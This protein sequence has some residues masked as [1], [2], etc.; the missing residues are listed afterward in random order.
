M[1][2]KYF[3]KGVDIDYLFES[4]SDGSLGSFSDFPRINPSSPEGDYQNQDTMYQGAFLQIGSELLNNY[5]LKKITILTSSTGTDVLTASDSRR[6]VN[7]DTS[8]PMWTHFKFSISVPSG[9]GTVGSSHGAVTWDYLNQGGY[10]GVNNAVKDYI[11]D[12]NSLVNYNAN[13]HAA[14]IADQTTDG[15]TN[16]HRA[17]AGGFFRGRRKEARGN[18]NEIKNAIHHRYNIKN[19]SPAINQ[20]GTTLSLPATSPGSNG[21]GR[22]IQSNLSKAINI[23]GDKTIYLRKCS[24]PRGDGV[25]KSQQSQSYIYVSKE[26]VEQAD[27]SKLTFPY[28]FISM[29][30]GQSCSSSSGGSITADNVDHVETESDLYTERVGDDKVVTWHQIHRVHNMG[31]DVHAGNDGTTGENSSIVVSKDTIHSGNILDGMGTT[32]IPPGG[33]SAESAFNNASVVNSVGHYEA[34]DGN[35]YTATTHNNNTN[36]IE[37]FMIYNP[38]VDTLGYTELNY[39]PQPEPE[40]EPEPEPE[41]DSKKVHKM[42]F[43]VQSGTPNINQVAFYAYV[44]DQIQNV[45]HSITDSTTSSGQGGSLVIKDRVDTDS[46]D[47]ATGDTIEIALSTDTTSDIYSS[48][49]VIE[50]DFPSEIFGIGFY[51]ETD[52]SGSTIDT[53]IRLELF[54]F[55][56]VKLIDI[57]DA[58]FS[59]TVDD[60][61]RSFA[62]R[63]LLNGTYEGINS[64]IDS[65]PAIFDFKEDFDSRTVE[66]YNPSD[67]DNDLMEPEPEP[68]PQPEPEFG[69]WNEISPD[70]DSEIVIRYIGLELPGSSINLS[71]ILVEASIGIDDAEDHDNAGVFNVLSEDAAIGTYVKGLPENVTYY[72]TDEGGEVE[73]LTDSSNNVISSG[74][75]SLLIDLNT[76]SHSQSG[77]TL[78]QLVNCVIKL[79]DTQVISGTDFDGLTARLYDVDMDL[80][81]E[82]TYTVSKA[83]EINFIDPTFSLVDDFSGYIVLAFPGFITAMVGTETG[84]LK[85]SSSGDY[86]SDLGTGTPIDGNIWVPFYIQDDRIDYEPAPEPEPEAPSDA[87]V[88]PSITVELW[89]AAGSA[90]AAIYGGHSITA[91]AGGYVRANLK[92]ASGTTLYIYCGTQPV[93]KTTSST[94]ND[95]YISL[96]GGWNGGGNGIISGSGSSYSTS[97]ATGYVS[98][99][100]GSTD[101]RL[102]PGS[103]L[104]DWSDT[105]S[106]NSRIA[107]AGGAGGAGGVGADGGHLQTNGWGY[108]PGSGGYPTGGSGYSNS[109]DVRAASGGTQSAGG[110]GGQADSY[111]GSGSNGG[112]GYGGSGAAAYNFGGQY[113]GGSGGGGGWYGGGGAG[114][115]RSGG[116]GSSYVDSEYL[117]GEATYVSQRSFPGPNSSY[118]PDTGTDGNYNSV[119][120][121]FN[122]SY[123]TSSPDTGGDGA[124]RITDWNGNVT[125]FHPS[126]KGWITG[127]YWNYA[128]YQTYVVPE[129]NSLAKVIFSAATVNSATQS[130]T[131]NVILHSGEYNDTKTVVGEVVV[132]TQY[133]IYN[134]TGDYWKTFEIEIYRENQVSL[135]GSSELSV[136]FEIVPPSGNTSMAYYDLDDYVAIKNIS[137]KRL[138]DSN[139]KEKFNNVNFS[140]PDY[141]TFFRTYG[142]YDG[143]NDS[144]T[145]GGPITQFQRFPYTVHNYI[146][147]TKLHTNLPLNR[148]ITPDSCE[149]S[150]TLAPATMNIKENIQKQGDNDGQDGENA[151]NLLKNYDKFPGKSYAL[152]LSDES[153]YQISIE[154]P[155]QVQSNK[156]FKIIVMA[157]FTEDWSGTPGPDTCTLIHSRFFSSYVKNKLDETSYEGDFAFDRSQT[158]YSSSSHSQDGIVQ[159]NR[160]RWVQYMDII[161]TDDMTISATGVKGIELYLGYNSVTTAGKIYIGEVKIL[162]PDNVNL[163]ENSRFDRGTH[164]RDIYGGVFDSRQGYGSYVI[165]EVP[166]LTISDQTSVMTSGNSSSADGT[167]T[168]DRTNWKNDGPMTATHALCLQYDQVYQIR[169]RWFIDGNAAGHSQG[170]A[171]GDTYAP[172]SDTTAGPTEDVGLFTDPTLW[173]ESTQWLEEYYNNG[174]VW[175]IDVYFSEDWDG[176]AVGFFDGQ[177]N[178]HF[179]R[180]ILSS[181]FKNNVNKSLS[182]RTGSREIGLIK[183]KWHRIYLFM[184]GNSTTGYGTPQSN[185][186]QGAYHTLFFNRTKGGSTGATKG[187]VLITN[188]TAD[189]AYGSSGSTWGGRFDSLSHDF[190]SGHDPARIT[191]SSYSTNFGYDSD[192]VADTE[193][194]TIVSLIERDFRRDFIISN[195]TALKITNTS[196]SSSYNHGGV[197]QINLGQGYS[198]ENTGGSVVNINPLGDA[199]ET[200]TINMK[201]YL[202]DD[203]FP[204]HSYGTVH[205]MIQAASAH[206]GSHIVNCYGDPVVPGWTLNSDISSYRN[207]WIDYTF[208]TP[209][210]ASSAGMLYFTLGGIGG[211][212]HLNNVWTGSIYIKDVVITANNAGTTL[213]SGIPAAGQI[214]WGSL[215]QF[216]PDPYNGGYWA[217][218]DENEIVNFANHVPPN[219]VMGTFRSSGNDN[220]NLIILQ[221]NQSFPEITTGLD[222]AI[223]MKWSDYHGGA[224]GTGA[225]DGN[226]HDVDYS[227]YNRGT[228]PSDMV[229]EWGMKFDTGS[230]ANWR[231]Y[232][233]SEGSSITGINHELSALVYVSDDF[234]GRLTLSLVKDD[235][236]YHSSIFLTT[237]TDE[238]RLYKGQWAEYKL[239]VGESSTTLGNYLYYSVGAGGINITSGFMVVTSIS[240]IGPHSDGLYYGQKLINRNFDDGHPVA[241]LYSGS[242]GDQNADLENIFNGISA[243][244]QSTHNIVELIYHVPIVLNPNWSYFSDI[245]D[246]TEREKEMRRIGALHPDKR[247]YRESLIPNN[248]IRLGVN[249]ITRYGFFANAAGGIYWSGP[250]ALRLSFLAFYP[251]DHYYTG[252]DINTVRLDDTDEYCLT[253]QITGIYSGTYNHAN[254]MNK[255]VRGQWRRYYHWVVGDVSLDNGPNDFIFTVGPGSH[256]QDAWTTSIYMTG[257]QVE[258]Y[259]ANISKSGLSPARNLFIDLGLNV[260]IGYTGY[261][262]G[263]TTGLHSTYKQGGSFDG[264]QYGPPVSGNTSGVDE[265]GNNIYWGQ[266]VVGVSGIRDHYTLSGYVHPLPPSISYDSSSYKFNSIMIERVRENPTYTDGTIATGNGMNAF[267][268]HELQVW[269]YVDNVATNIAVNPTNVQSDTTLG[270]YYAEHGYKAKLTNLQWYI[271]GASGAPFA[272]FNDN[273][274]NYNET[275]GIYSAGGAY[276]EG[277]DWQ[278]Q[279]WQLWFNEEFPIN[280]LIGIVMYQDHDGGTVDRRETMRGCKVSLV[281]GEYLNPVT[282]LELDE[283]TSGDITIDYMDPLQ[284]VRCEWEEI[285]EARDA[286]IF[287]GPRYSHSSP[288]HIT[289]SSSGIASSSQLALTSWASISKILNGK[290]GWEDP[291]TMDNLFTY[292]SN[293][294]GRI[295]YNN[296]ALGIRNYRW[297]PFTDSNI[298]DSDSHL[299]MDQHLTI[300][301]DIADGYTY[302]VSENTTISNNR[303][304]YRSSD[305]IN[306]IENFNVRDIIDNY[307]ENFSS[308]TANTY[309]NEIEL[310]VNN[311]RIPYYYEMLRSNTDLQEGS[312]ATSNV[313]EKWTDIFMDGNRNYVT[314][315]ESPYETSLELT[316]YWPILRSQFQAALISH[317]LQENTG[318]H[319]GDAAARAPNNDYRDTWFRIKDYDGTTIKNFNKHQGYRW[320]EGINGRLALSESTDFRNAGY[321]NEDVGYHLEFTYTP[322]AFVLVRGETFESWTSDYTTNFIPSDQSIGDWSNDTNINLLP[323]PFVT[324]RDWYNYYH[325]GYAEDYSIE[326]YVGTGQNQTSFDVY[327]NKTLSVLSLDL[328]TSPG[329]YL[330]AP[331]AYQ[332]NYAGNT[333]TSYI[334]DRDWDDVWVSP[335]DRWNAN[336]VNYSVGSGVPLTEVFRGDGSYPSGATNQTLSYLLANGV[337][338]NSGY[339]DSGSSDGTTLNRFKMGEDTEYYLEDIWWNQSQELNLKLPTNADLELFASSSDGNSSSSAHDVCDLYFDLY[340]PIGTTSSYVEVTI[341]HQMLFGNAKVFV[342][343][344]LGEYNGSEHNG[345]ISSYATTTARITGGYNRIL[346]RCVNNNNNGNE[347]GTGGTG[348]VAYGVAATQYESRSASEWN[349]G[350]TK[351]LL[352]FATG[353]S[354]CS[355]GGYT[356]HSMDSWGKGWKWKRDVGSYITGA[357]I[358]FASTV[359]SNTTNDALLRWI[360]ESE[361]GSG[362]KPP[363]GTLTIPGNTS[364]NA[365]TYVASDTNN[366]TSVDAAGNV[367]VPVIS[368]AASYTYSGTQTTTQ[369]YTATDIFGNVLSASRTIQV[370]ASPPSMSGST[371]HTIDSWSGTNVINVAINGTQAYDA[372]GTSLPVSYHN[373]S[374]IGLNHPKRNGWVQVKATDQWGQ[375]SYRTV[376]IYIRAQ[377][378]YRAID[379]GGAG[380]NHARYNGSA[381][382]KLPSGWPNNSEAIPYGFSVR[383]YQGHPDRFK[384]STS[385]SGGRSIGSNGWNNGYTYSSWI[386]VERTDHNGGWGQNLKLWMGVYAY[387][388][389]GQ[390]AHFTRGNIPGGVSGVYQYDP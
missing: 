350:S 101:I 6:Y 31:I 287:E 71:T 91:I 245:T 52:Q 47:Y 116:G 380:G 347:S 195:E 209:T 153:E 14:G 163:I 30:T 49:S 289:P 102:I 252:D 158:I 360:L 110:V 19:G 70:G 268:F 273:S 8:L 17:R 50:Y 138:N 27:G 225:G 263:E 192:A 78:D 2:G 170:Q 378:Y 64:D 304:G 13:T 45:V 1:S 313:E 140:Y 325:S 215:G 155:T 256:L 35:W 283:G 272:A 307:T 285:N 249:E 351:K 7:G 331:N 65:F 328:R 39:L 156:T 117:E 184:G 160:G 234:V 303:Y 312:G 266:Y 130:I 236:S 389:S 180:S 196:T 388:S 280:D 297:M 250:M 321:S 172:Y 243:T 61:G 105:T 368:P 346:F 15:G 384:I 251:E 118:F 208:T 88:E 123:L 131:L 310:F 41:P 279:R 306:S 302:N 135:D 161:N 67:L 274:I 319:G 318:L 354:F 300:K 37:L 18:I 114:T 201:I 205:L 173:H 83:D 175:G 86:L 335:E 188:I 145:S 24:G 79:S 343:N 9:Q 294:T 151:S 235:T 371:S 198:D 282:G 214:Q 44:E 386:R 98:G 258:G 377:R 177:I 323:Y 364:T 87:Y 204:S 193:D 281:N 10:N 365:P 308:Y 239:V 334:P 254:T 286:F 146:E 231:G 369:T 90:G 359:S 12:N 106:L 247:P 38:G 167:F 133:D 150:F 382:W 166:N 72:S 333:G 197:V 112:F 115:S 95:A 344:T 340:N 111:T 136:T 276:G 179:D 261:T 139:D 143:L 338:K 322:S 103:S 232:V 120:Q 383:D 200:W 275:G 63:C 233:N 295:E 290:K 54:N 25:A 296:V 219:G 99:G 183:G 168:A 132:P 375:T 211:T 216:D 22:T 217:G 299:R 107:V 148:N 100:G 81:F 226:T 53:S 113:R 62:F 327:L 381:H 203:Y 248:A 229:A 181:V 270:P 329:L 293:V 292:N 370:I 218:T 387:S 137:V 269:V 330:T 212:V 206:N 121:S 176:D 316:L 224:T 147:N 326:A 119:N 159:V 241:P 58:G 5:P 291:T 46:F 339:T 3:Y 222:T 305:F 336:V 362:G 199:S 186:G 221:G 257:F 142:I 182:L 372:A 230:S 4:G 357:T 109:A 128:E 255:I 122:Y 66:L 309:I 353:R 149:G 42:R 129:P 213:Y 227:Q 284:E 40:S 20:N 171:A 352:V 92:V 108:S 187:Y 125:V 84:Y 349:N 345:S 244:T 144:G 374:N 11:T 165:E 126:N 317:E 264:N 259:N 265:N 76:S 23:E 29:E 267:R 34:G 96:Q 157:Y 207:R 51:T 379:V 74:G 77:F 16:H 97:N 94:P 202:G 342:L 26:N 73:L 178:Q 56:G 69:G 152:V 228:S 390:I 124:C 89:G 332:S 191:S 288:M 127:G 33:N 253:G 238:N 82:R 363:A 32:Y 80:R 162:D 260:A 190:S 154:L 36:S 141:D 367:V 341:Y 48:G 169:H 358:P 75:G 220:H 185:N 240:L 278:G 373:S 164:I 43:T 55:N 246:E 376:N 337:R 93:P 104:I 237:N 271:G 361:Y 28:F 85:P 348:L 385:S 223:P 262:D 189:W 194:A 298:V 21:N 57:S 366:Y 59:G 320:I 356:G 315:K 174:L 210:S 68:E 134:E 242:N 355:W 301:F 311:H 60:E 314:F 277:D 324:A